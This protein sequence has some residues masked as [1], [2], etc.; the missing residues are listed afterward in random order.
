MDTPIS[1]G[2]VIDPV[3]SEP[4]FIERKMDDAPRSGITTTKST[5]HQHLYTQHHRRNHSNGCDLKL[6]HAKVLSQE[7]F[8]Y[9]SNVVST[10]VMLCPVAQATRSSMTQA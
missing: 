5:Q 1:W 7:R 2:G 3:D 4:M 6:I 9:V 10:L 8:P